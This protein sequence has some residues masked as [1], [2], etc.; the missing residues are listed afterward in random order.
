MRRFGTGSHGC[1]PRGLAC[2]A[3]LL[4]A[5]ASVPSVV[6]F[7]LAQGQ[8]QYRAGVRA[9]EQRNYDEAFEQYQAALQAD[10]SNIQ[11]LMAFRRMRFQAGAMHVVRGEEL[12][13]QG[14]LAGALAEFER[15]AMIDP[16]S[17]IALQSIQQV[18]TLIEQ[19]ATGQVPADQ[20]GLESLEEAL[21]PPQ[22][23]PLSRDPIN[24]RMSNNSRV[25][26]ETIGR[27]A[28]INVLFDLDFMARDVSVDLSN[29]TLEEA[30]DQVSILT[31][32]FWKPVTRNTILVLPDTTVKRREQE[33]QILKTF[34]LSNTIT[35]QELTEVV[36]AIRSLLETRRIQQVNSMNAIIIRD[37][38]DKVAL[39][40][41]IIRDVDKAKPEVVV[42]V[43]VLEVRR[44]LTRQIGL[45][46]TSPAGPGISTTV[47]PTP[48]TTTTGGTTTPTNQIPLSRIGRLSSGDFSITLPGAQLNALLNDAN[49]KILQ[50]PEVRASDNQRATL[51]IGDRR[52]IATGA[53]Q[54]GVGGTLNPLVQTQ[55]QYI[56][57]GVNLDIT[58][59]VHT[60]DEVTLAVRVEISAVT[61]EVEIG[62]IVQPIIG[63]RIIEHNIRLRE[64]EINVLGGIF[65]RQN[66]ER[67]TGVPGLAQVPLLRYIFSNVN[68]TIAEDEVLVVLRPHA[69]RRPDISALNLKALDIGTE[70]DV[71]LRS[72]RALPQPPAG[73]APEN[74]PAPDAPPAPGAPP[75]P[76]AALRFPEPPVAKSG[77]TFEVPVAIE[78]AVDAVG[79]SLQL[80]YDPRAVRLLRIVKGEFFG[81][82]E[83]PPVAIVERTEHEAGSTAVTL[84]RPP[85]SGSISGSGEL[86]VLTFQALQ[87]G[88]TALG[89]APA[90][91][92]TPSSRDVPIRGAQAVL[93][94]Q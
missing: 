92:I 74:A 68:T 30:L 91:I 32:S 14:D 11:Y 90:G 72:P 59:K 44:D 67:V 26:F 66:V 69:V 61:N 70:G 62:G 46:P 29:V 63:Q 24:L 65:Q 64:G 53:F 19:Q 85:G 35:P 28:G 1:W 40:E 41:K 60:N 38:P 45:F 52:P 47:T 20:S 21:G 48:G 22:L 17:P 10:P 81:G 6:P 18:R 33:Q 3:L 73:P 78:N 77:E 88:P 49:T 94:I 75:G 84:S 55:F 80:A 36:T 39:A 79:V 50:R 51:R 89:V 13:T 43:A 83:A 16:S 34:Y 57:V 7:L 15:A 82:S 56:D 42:D 5:A 27:L 25:V 23:E 9:E 93:T 4:A 87:P 86:A 58:P 12:R 2:L 8:D 37:T 76:G 71:R 54:A 31:R